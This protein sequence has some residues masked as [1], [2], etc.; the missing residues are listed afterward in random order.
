MQVL[1][2]PNIQI[3]V[4]YLSWMLKLTSW[5]ISGVYS[6]WSAWENFC[7]QR[8]NNAFLLY[9]PIIFAISAPP[10]SVVNS[11]LVVLEPLTHNTAD[12][13]KLKGVFSLIQWTNVTIMSYNAS[14]RTSSGLGQLEITR[15]LCHFRHKVRTRNGWRSHAW[16]QL[17]AGC[18]T[19]FCCS[20]CSRKPCP[21]SALGISLR[22]G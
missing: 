7:T 1:S 12:L 16:L 6:I 8:K 4:T 5:Y 14:S 21:V 11:C 10:K 18:S 19:A 2:L 17:L 15:L 9:F 22:E 13:N 20:H 3:F